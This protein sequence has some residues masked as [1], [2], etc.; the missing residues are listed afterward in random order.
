MKKLFRDTLHLWMAFLTAVAAVLIVNSIRDFA[1][2]NALAMAILS[3]GTGSIVGGCYFV[4]VYLWHWRKRRHA[5]A[6]IANLA[7]QGLDAVEKTRDDLGITCDF[8][9]CEKDYAPDAIRLYIPRKL[10]KKFSLKPFAE[11]LGSVLW[12][13]YSDYI[14]EKSPNNTLPKLNKLC[15]AIID[16]FIQEFGFDSGHLFHKKFLPSFIARHPGLFSEPMKEAWKAAMA[17]HQKTRKEEELNRIRE[18]GLKACGI[19]TK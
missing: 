12:L 14:E 2:L 15:R 19:P 17:D 13:A 1:S 3:V 4:V 18:H 9:V 5:D 8:R 11:L 16:S 6:W 10:W 7:D